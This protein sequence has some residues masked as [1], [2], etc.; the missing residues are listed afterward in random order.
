MRWLSARTHQNRA[1]VGQLFLPLVDRALPGA[2][3]ALEPL[4]WFVTGILPEGAPA[5]DVLLIHWLN[6]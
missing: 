5:G 4:G 2:V 6:E 1:E 3:A